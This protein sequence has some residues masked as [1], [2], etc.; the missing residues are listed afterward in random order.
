MLSGAETIHVGGVLLGCI[1]SASRGMST[2]L[3]LLTG[4]LTGLLTRKSTKRKAETE[5]PRGCELQSVNQA[6]L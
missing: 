5:G 6:S 2:E 1:D 4:L 3:T